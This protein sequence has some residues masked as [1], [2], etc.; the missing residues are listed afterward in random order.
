[1]RKL[2][3]EVDVC[4][5]KVLKD[6]HTALL[7]KVTKSVAVCWPSICVSFYHFLHRTSS[8]WCIYH[9]SYSKITFLFPNLFISYLPIEFF[10]A[11]ISSISCCPAAFLSTASLSSIL[12]DSHEYCSRRSSTRR[13]NPSSKQESALLGDINDFGKMP[14]NYLFRRSNSVRAPTVRTVRLITPLS[15][16]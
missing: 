3:T 5:W 8:G 13:S 11:L 12:K 16:L 9:F 14:S 7:W 2:P 10:V 4:H 1:M 6:R 15:T